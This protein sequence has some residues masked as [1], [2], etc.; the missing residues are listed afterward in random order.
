MIGMNTSSD[1]HLV[2]I[3]ND[4]PRPTPTPTPRQECCQMCPDWIMETICFFL[5]MGSTI[6]MVLFTPLLVYHV[7]QLWFKPEH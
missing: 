4:I 7:I 2:D 5:F 6:L 1:L 3:E